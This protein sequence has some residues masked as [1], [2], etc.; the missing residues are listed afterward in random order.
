[1]SLRD[2]HFC[3]RTHEKQRIVVLKTSFPYWMLSNRNLLSPTLKTK[4]SRKHC[5]KKCEFPQMRRFA[6]VRNQQHREATRKIGLPKSRSPD[7]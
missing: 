4:N 2:S 6:I 5:F 1:M 7:D 3:H